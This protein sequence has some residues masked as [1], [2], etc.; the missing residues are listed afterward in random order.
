[1]SP[2]RLARLLASAGAV[3]LAAVLVVALWLVRHRASGPL[4][5]KAVGVV[6]G[7][8]LHA[9]NFHWT[10]MKGDRKQW[11]LSAAEASYSNDKTRIALRDAQLMM[12][13][14]DGKQVSV[15]AP[16]VELTMAGN[17]VSRAELSGGLRVSYG[18]VMLAAEQASFSPDAD[19]LDAPGAITIETEGLKVRGVGLTAWPRRQL[20]ALRSQ[21]ITEVTPARGR[22]DKPP[23]PGA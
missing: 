5:S 6:P 19:E 10:Q 16:R 7:A 11:E 14:E 17:H 22:G 1:M 3:A 13:A 4:L 12:I 18:T 9:H 2:R 8:L 23:S 20:F 21:V 15:R